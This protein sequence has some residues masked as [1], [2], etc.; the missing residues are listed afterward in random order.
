MNKGFYFFRLF[1][2][3][4]PRVVFIMVGGALFFGAYEKSC[5]IIE[6]KHKRLF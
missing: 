5:R 2:G 1:A 6:D 3:F 4:L